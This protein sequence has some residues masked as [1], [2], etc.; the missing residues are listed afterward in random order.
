[1]SVDKIAVRSQ[2]FAIPRFADLEGR[3]IDSHLAGNFRK[4]NP[5]LFIIAFDHLAY[6]K[7][8]TVP[9]AGAS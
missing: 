3:F 6:G 4:P 7:S 8:G 1:M 2:I 5:Q 9:S